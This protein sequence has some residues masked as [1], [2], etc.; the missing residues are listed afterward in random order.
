MVSV[1]S[2]LLAFVVGKL[3]SNVELSTILLYSIA[4]LTVLV[5]IGII[6]KVNKI[7]ARGMWVALILIGQA[8]IFYLLYIQQAT[9]IMLFAKHNMRLDAYPC[10]N[11]SSI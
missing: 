2:I 5:Y 10:W 11:Y 7:E 6:F 9:S 4:V 3:L 1:I 8:I